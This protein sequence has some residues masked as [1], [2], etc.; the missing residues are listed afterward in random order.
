MGFG[1]LPN[2]PGSNEKFVQ[3]I[4]VRKLEEIISDTFI[5]MKKFYDGG[6]GM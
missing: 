5:Y 2:T 4:V 6:L 3:K 1:E